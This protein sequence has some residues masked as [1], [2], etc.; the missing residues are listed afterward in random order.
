M[1]K[2]RSWPVD[3]HPVPDDHRVSNMT[4]A[5]GHATEVH[6][7]GSFTNVLLPLWSSVRNARGSMG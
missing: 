7:T 3:P 6:Y 5:T 2:P 1:D 4:I